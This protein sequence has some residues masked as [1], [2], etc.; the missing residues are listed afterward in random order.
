M[1][2]KVEVEWIERTNKYV[3]VE[4]DSLEELSHLK[5]LNSFSIFD[6]LGTGKENWVKLEDNSIKF[7]KLLG[8]NNETIK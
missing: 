8:G 6:W 3:T 2:I 5:N 4:V 7:K 1:S